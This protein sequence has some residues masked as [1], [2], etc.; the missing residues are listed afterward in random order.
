MNSS[1]Q[2]VT[3]RHHCL[4]LV[5]SVNDQRSHGTRLFTAALYHLT[6]CD[7]SQL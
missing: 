2:D 1:K 5:R 7:Q 6:S 4:P 3:C